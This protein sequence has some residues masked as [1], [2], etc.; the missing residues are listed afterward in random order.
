M[1]DQGTQQHA[2]PLTE[3]EKRVLELVAQGL[4]LRETAATINNS[5]DEVHISADE[6]RIV[7]LAALT[8]LK[9]TNVDPDPP[10]SLPQP[11]LTRSRSRECDLRT[12]PR[13]PA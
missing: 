11:Y 10:P 5:P 2:V 12:S 8:K 4:S 3:I 9:P 6:V 1:D 7:L 13:L